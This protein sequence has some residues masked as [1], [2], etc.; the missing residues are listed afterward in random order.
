MKAAWGCEERSQMSVPAFVDDG[1]SLIERNKYKREEHNAYWNC[2]IRW[3]PDNVY[4][5]LNMY[6]SIKMFPNMPMPA[7]KDMSKRF[8]GAV[9]YYES[10]Y[11]EY[12]I[13][14][15]ENK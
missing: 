1:F 11:N 7:Y 10:K 12:S 9:Q 13:L 3:I 5:L 2:P 4:K 15:M 6:D 14:A 8:L